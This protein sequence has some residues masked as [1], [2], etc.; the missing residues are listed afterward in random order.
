MTEQNF[1]KE[2]LTYLNKHFTYTPDY[3]W[4]DAGKFMTLNNTTIG[5]ALHG[6]CEDYSFHVARYVLGDGTLKTFYKS[7]WEGDFEFWW[8]ITK[9]GGNHCILIDNLA[10]KAIDNWV[11]SFV[12]IDE[13][14]GLHKF[15]YRLP[16]IAVLWMLFAGV[17]DSGVKK[18][19]GK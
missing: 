2:A 17:L 11:K 5:T 15:K 10:D 9:S 14:Q 18:L 7:L 16:T 19:F 3:K 12:S 6:D 1:N 13:M 4:W 8:V